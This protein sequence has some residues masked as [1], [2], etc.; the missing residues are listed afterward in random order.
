MPCEMRP[1][2]EPVGVRQAIGE[3]WGDAHAIR[4]AVQVFQER[5]KLNAIPRLSGLWQLGLVSGAVALSR[6]H[7]GC[8]RVPCSAA[9][10]SLR[11]YTGCT[12]QGSD[13][14]GDPSLS[15]CQ[16]RDA[17]WVAAPV[18]IRTLILFLA[19][20]V[21]IVGR[22]IRLQP[23]GI[24]FPPA[25]RIFIDQRSKG[26]GAGQYY[27]ADADVV[28]LYFGGSWNDTRIALC[29]DCTT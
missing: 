28:V 2:Q 10:P 7:L 24:A 27:W 20:Q 22:L 26:F 13:R 25:A 8:S 11:G 17:G 15:T 4:A 23:L 6:R 3:D 1:T 16:W 14:W 9:L 21:V 29:D 19:R 18:L 5:D 12:A